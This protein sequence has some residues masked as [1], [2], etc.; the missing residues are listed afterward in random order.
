[1]ASTKEVVELLFQA[2]YK[3]QPEMLK[4][5][6]DVSGLADSFDSGVRRTAAMTVALGTLEVAALGASVGL[7]KASAESAG[8]FKDNFAEISTLITDIS[9]KDLAGF[10]LAIKDYATNSTASLESINGAIY[11]AISAGVDWENSLAFLAEAEKLSVAGKA[12]LNDTVKVLTATLN[13]YGESTDQ[14]GKYS[15]VL[16]NTVKN[17]VTTLP[18]LSSQLGQV[19]GIAA[20]LNIPFDELSAVIATLTA[21][22]LSTGNAITAIKGALTN[23]IKPTKQASEA[24]ESLGIGFDYAALQSKGFSG[25]MGEIAQ[26]ST[27]NSEAV[28]KLFGSVEGLNAALSLTSDKGA[29]AFI[30]KLAEMQNSTGATEDAFQKM[31]ENTALLKQTLAN[32]LELTLVDI[33]TPILDEFHDIDKAIIEIFKTIRSNLENDSTLGAVTNAVEGV[34]KTVADIIRNMADNLDDAL[35]QADL[36]GFVDAF[37]EINKA[38]DGMDLQTTEGLA[39]AIEAVGDA[40][41]GLT[42]FMVA[43]GEVLGGLIGL[44]AEAGTSLSELD[45]DTLALAGSVGGAAVAIAALS[46]VLSPL[47]AVLTAIKKLGGVSGS[48][49][50]A[51]EVNKMAKSV[52]ALGVA[53]ASLG[54]GF[55]LG[56]WFAEAT[57]A[58]FDWTGAI[59]TATDQAGPEMIKMF[60]AWQ[61]ETG[62]LNATFDDYTAAMVKKRREEE[63]SKNAVD[64]LT[65]SQKKLNSASAPVSDQQLESWRQY[66]DV[67]LD[68]EGNILE[69]TTSNRESSAAVGDHNTQLKK[70]TQSFDALGSSARDAKNDLKAIDVLRLSVTLESDRVKA[71]AEKVKAIM[72]SLGETGSAVADSIAAGFNA[73]GTDGFNNL[74]IFQKGDLIESIKVQSEAQKKLAEAQEKVAAAQANY[75]NAKAKQMSSGKGLI[76]IDGT[77]L[78]PELEAFMLRII[79]FTQIRLAEE[80]SGFLLGI[81]SL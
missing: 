6:K 73:I 39:D 71:E 3:G 17:G 11:N 38:L 20:S 1:M 40:F 53:G 68:A 64:D 49:G 30:D 27:G 56:E 21:N 36:S 72:D 23:I 7:A 65:E 24:A 16:F 58:V 34:A 19:T 55:V 70:T 5:K 37:N 61:V 8:K 22:G 26:K 63:S 9:D 33:G 57:D 50:S 13:A 74:D 66:G 81:E 10:E 46:A 78:E 48:L 35:A 69:F 12:D 54:G 43:A 60:K 77:R 80:Q 67:V 47:I 44:V 51:A 31:M 76:Q 2:D 42:K 59:E 45:G 4:L 25:L 29:Q 41:E 15:D 62:R 32:N 79:E 14:A 75:M 52:K 18:E 28:T